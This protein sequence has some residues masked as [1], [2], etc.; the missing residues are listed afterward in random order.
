MLVGQWGGLV[1]R[2]KGGRG[3]RGG[4]LEVGKEEEILGWR[5]RRDLGMGDEG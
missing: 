2:R 3:G 5:G 1:G 4:G